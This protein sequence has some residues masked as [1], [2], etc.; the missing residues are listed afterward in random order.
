LKK[1]NFLWSL[2]SSVKLAITLLCFIIFIFIVATLVPQQNVSPAIA[3]LSDIYHSKIFYILTGLFSLNLVICSLNRWPVSMKQF[4]ASC[5]PAPSGIFSNLS[6]NRIIFTD[7]KMEDVERMVQS[8]LSSK[9]KQVQTTDMEK[10]RLFCREE[11]RFSLFGVYI[12]HLGV[13]VIIAGAV[14][15]SI[16]GFDADINLLEGQESNIVQLLKDKGTRELDFSVRCDKFLVEF[17]D[18]GAPKTYRSDLSFIKNGQVIRQGS[19]MVNYPVTF[20]GLRFYQSSYGTSEQTKA[21]LRYNNADGE[22]KD[23]LIAQG[24]TFDLSEQNAKATVLRVEEDMM[25]FGPAVKL[26]IKTDKGHIQFWVFQ[27]IQQI[28]DVNPG[29]FSSVPLFNPGL[30]KPLIFSLQRIE[31]QFYTGLLVV[32]DPGVPFVLAGGVMLVAG[33]MII[34]FFSHQH[35]WI[36]IEQESKGIKISVAGRSNRYNEALQRQ[37]DE[38]CTRMEKEIAS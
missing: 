36:F 13:L 1:T 19:V 29:L 24:S 26:D 22:S 16:F 2:F 38:L 17:Y 34:F 32:R 8:F 4:N 27:H 37:L 28:A 3:W 18:T 5:S 10:G 7:K 30:F 12:V 14:I 15:G 33:M 21:L 35:I 25:Q 9:I 6:Q 20:E 31:K 23:V 11:G